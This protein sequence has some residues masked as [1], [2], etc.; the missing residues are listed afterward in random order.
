[1]SVIGIR[2]EDKNEWERRAPLTPSDVAALVSANGLRVIVES[3]NHRIHGDGEYLSAGAEIADGL[4]EAGVIFAVKEVPAEKLLP[5]RVYVFFAHVV[6]GQRRNMPLLEE[7]LEKRVT[8]IDYERI[9]DERGRRLICFGRHAGLA[10]MIDSLHFLGRR[11][12]WEGHETAL[13]DLRRA[14]EYEDLDDAKSAVAEIGER[15]SRGFEIDDAPLVVG[16]TGA[17]HVSRGAQEVF[18]LLPHEEVTPE[19]LADLGEESRASCDRLYKVVF[20]K[21]HLAQPREPGKA[22]DEDE[23]RCHP[24]RFRGGR[25]VRYLPHVTLLMNGVFWTPDYPRFLTRKEAAAMWMAGGQKLRLIGDVTCDVAGS[26]E[27]DYKTMTPARPT[28]VFDPT[29][30]AF[31]DGHEGPGIIV[32]AVDNLPCEL[33]RDSSRDFSRVLRGLVPG[34]ARADYSRPFAELDLPP[35]IRRA[36]VTHQGRLAPEYDYLEEYLE[37]LE[38]A[39]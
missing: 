19:D 14:F 20:R 35:E 31:R 33:P 6:K 27:I 25:L 37:D 38:F 18:D 39:L 34:I 16:F 29:S 22:F 26:I 2:M 21:R 36:V 17:G 32:L 11:L 15:L 24:E 23:Y 13:A 4:D 30:N 5:E 1:M 9:A 8:M 28:Y 7:L 10:G 12:E 3:S